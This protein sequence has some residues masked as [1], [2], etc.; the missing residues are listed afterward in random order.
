V[1]QIMLLSSSLDAMQA[2][3]TRLVNEKFNTVL[4]QEPATSLG[5]FE[6]NPIDLVLVDLDNP[7]ITAGDI[8]H[9]KR[10]K[11]RRQLPVLAIVAA[12]Y[13][14]KVELISDLDDFI[15]Q[16]VN[17]A[18]LTIRINR[19]LKKA[20]RLIGREIIDCGP[21][22]IDT[23]KCEVYL[24]DTS[25]SLTFKEYELLK[26]L[27]SNRGRVFTRDA[28]LN[29]VWDYEYFGGDRTVDVHITRLRSKI[30]VTGYSFIETVRNIGYKFMAIKE[31]KGFVHG[32]EN[33]NLTVSE[34]IVKK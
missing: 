21:L 2:I 33:Q 26:F 28:L 3:K 31:S 9:L 8:L 5:E 15:T 6:L 12:D 24:D 30:E 29:E 34:M 11:N 32:K 13:V 23:A 14:K 4:V 20:N 18:E 19:A 1:P 10:M 16:P 25:L 27:A 7:T 17:I 22:I